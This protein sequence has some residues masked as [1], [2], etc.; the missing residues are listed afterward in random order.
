MV[1]NFLMFPMLTFYV[2]QYIIKIY[3]LIANKVVIKNIVTKHRRDNF[4]TKNFTRR[5]LDVLNILFSSSKPMTSSDIIKS[6][7]D[8][9]IQSTVMA[10]LRKLL[11]EGYIQEE[12]V[13]Y[14]GTVLSR[15]YVVTDLA[16][17]DVFQHFAKTYLPLMESIG[18][19]AFVT[20]I[21][22][23]LDEDKQKEQR[24]QLREM[25]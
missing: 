18:L 13:V 25:L 5:E 4:M 7:N 16:R 12:G 8:D 2:K 6:S 15:T 14:C 9:L 22:S 19:P 1:N 17:R 23:L 11:K 21:L 24:D 20:E 3:L 10:V